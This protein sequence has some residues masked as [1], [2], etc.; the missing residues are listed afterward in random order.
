MRFS[1]R[2]IS[3]LMMITGWSHSLF[4]AVIN[5]KDSIVMKIDNVSRDRKRW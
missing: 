1:V 5:G 3:I 4:A 2:Y